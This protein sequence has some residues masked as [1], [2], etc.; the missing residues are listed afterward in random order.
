VL[1]AIKICALCGAEFAR[2]T[3]TKDGR[4]QLR[5]PGAWRRQRFCSVACVKQYRL[6]GPNAWRDRPE[7]V[8]PN[9]LRELEPVKP[10]DEQFD[11]QYLPGHLRALE[12]VKPR[13]ERSESPD[14]LAILE[15][16]RR[17]YETLDEEVPHQP[18]SDSA[19]DAGRSHPETAPCG[20]DVQ[21]DWRDDAA[22]GFDAGRPQ[23]VLESDASHSVR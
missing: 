19:R 17:P 15:P 2:P 13:D 11:E 6:Q 14:Y 9:Y 22:A 23:G 7:T 3:H 18:R 21:P 4:R 20:Q 5:W 16:D 1:P 8:L 12:P 10:R